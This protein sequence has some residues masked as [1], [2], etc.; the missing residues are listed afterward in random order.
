MSDA[1]RSS[2]RAVS[3]PASRASRMVRVGSV[4]TG[5]AGNV[6]LGAARDLGRGARPKL[7]DLL[8]TPGN[9]RRF[10]DELAQMRGAAMK[11]GQLLSMDSGEL[12]PPELSDILA[13]LRDDAHFMPPRQL[14]QVLSASWGSDWLKNFKTFDVR[15]IAAASIGQVHR[16]VLRDGRTVAV[17]VQYP[18]IARSVD[19]D[20]SNVGAL[21]RLSGLLP[22][23]FDIAPYLDEAR[24]Q[25]REETDYLREGRCLAAFRRRLGDMPRF[26]VPEYHPD[27]SSESVLTMSFVAGAPIEAVRS[28]DRALREGIAE[29]LIDLLFRELFVWGEIQS[30]P[31]FANYRYNAE[32]GRIILLDFGATRTLSAGIVNLYGRLFRAGLNGDVEA[33]ASAVGDFGLF[34][35]GADPDHRAR[36]MTMVEWAF[37]AVR[38]SERYDFSDKTLSRRM[39]D[40]SLRLASEGYV[41]PPVPMDALYLQRKFAGLFLLASRLDASVPLRAILERWLPDSADAAA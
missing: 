2:A 14:K 33:L 16:A 22:K 15:P 38:S 13:R 18:G 1:T 19:S 24:R 31:N 17:K 29:D 8:V 23:G 26:E 10:T 3:V 39:Q 4:A 12:L 41:P 30:D 32:T 27:W 9:I 7:R 28:Q 25:L 36:I 40:E 21:V 5:I 37:D 11:V 35:E 34:P 6:A 20:V